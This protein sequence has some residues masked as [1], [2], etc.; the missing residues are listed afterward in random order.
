LKII[1]VNY[2]YFISGGPEKYLF[3][4]K[5][6][7]EKHG[8][9]VIPFSI[10]HNKNRP[11][12]YENYFMKPLGTGDE[13]YANE[14][15]KK[16][17][18]TILTVIGRMLYSFEAKRKIKKLIRDTQPDIVYLLYYQNKMSAS[19]VDGA[20]QMGVP[21]VQ[22]ISDFGHIC[23]DNLFYIYQK[24]EICE[25]CLHGSRLNAIRYRCVDNSVINSF[26]KVLA[27]K[28]QDFRNTTKKISAFVFPAEFTSNKFK[29]FGIPD[30]KRHHIPT[31]YNQA[32]EPAGEIMYDDFFLYV[33]RVDPDKGMLTLVKAFE[34]TPYRLIIIGSSIDGH[35]EFLKNHLIGKNHHITFLGKLEFTEIRPYLQRCLCTICP[36]EWY[37]NMPNT[38][39]ESYAHEKAV[40]A[41]GLGALLDEVPDY[42]TGLNFKVGNHIDLRAKVKLLFENKELAK[43]LGSKGK[44][45]LLK[46]YSEKQHYEKLID[47]FNTVKN[48]NN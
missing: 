2:R 9:A 28:I 29:E 16:N 26:L 38:V 1:L 7:L 46:E 17:L 14:Y 30:H 42:E 37:E 4:I 11:S 8:H 23:V 40:I 31:F 39:L 15:P 12:P 5:E 25:R 18:K 3:N 32:N 20:Y 10:R 41:S 44:Q 24:R 33:G 45:K 6:I 19:V 13:V 22:R 27:L 34:E 47:L 21:I 48:E 36:S 35:D 43:K